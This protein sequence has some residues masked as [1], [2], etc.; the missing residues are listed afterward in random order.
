MH[1]DSFNHPVLILNIEVTGPRSA[2]VQFARITSRGKRL[3]SHIPSSFQNDYLPIAPSEAHPNNG[4]LLRL[5]NE[6]SKRGM[7][8]ISYVSIGEGIFGLD[9]RALRCYSAGQKADGYRHRLQ[10]E[11]F[12]QVMNK[13]GRSPSEWIDTGHLWETFL[14]IHD[15]TWVDRF[16]P[17]RE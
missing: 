4:I 8:A 5:E 12:N 13:M 3:L 10:E 2:T 1:P 15:P 7:T 9:F 14:R 6:A 11:S 17:M 16:G